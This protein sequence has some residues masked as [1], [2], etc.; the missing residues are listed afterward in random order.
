MRLN[1]AEA[2]LRKFAV[3]AFGLALMG[4]VARADD[5]VVYGAGSLREAIGQIAAEFGRSH[6]LTVTTQFGPSG[7]MRERIEMGERADLFTS[8]DVGHAR[9][10]VEDGRASVMTVFVRNAV[11]L[12]SPAKFGA[13][14]ATALDKLLAPGVRFGM[15]PPKADPLGDYTERLFGLIDRLRAGS[16]AAMQARAVILDVPPGAPPPKSGD[17][18]ADA[19]IDGRVD[20]A[21]VYCSS[22]DRYARLLPDAAM[23]EFPAELQVGPEYGMAVLKDAQPMALLLA[24]TILSPS[25]QEILTKQGFKPVALPSDQQ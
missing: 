13:T 8:A 16:G 11:C 9:K 7:R 6:G 10:L 23:I 15:S 25:G 2:V 20:T 17:V 12:L 19:I 3:A 5:L 24:L 1:T 18:D 21:I 4:S 22:R 14:T